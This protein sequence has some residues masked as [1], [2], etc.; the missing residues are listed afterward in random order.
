[1]NLAE[2]IRCREQRNRIAMIGQLAGIAELLVAGQGFP[3]GIAQPVCGHCLRN[4]FGVIQQHLGHEVVQAL[5]NEVAEFAM[6]DAVRSIAP[7]IGTVVPFMDA[8]IR[9]RLVVGHFGKCNHRNAEAFA[10]ATCRAGHVFELRDIARSAGEFWEFR[11]QLAGGEF[12]HGRF[13]RS[14]SSTSQP[15]SVTT[16]HVRRSS[17]APATSR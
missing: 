2:I 16:K 5:E 1:M 11:E 4:A 6:M 15:R 3:C 10:E 12:F 7:A 13:F 17:G 9:S 14:S 8:H